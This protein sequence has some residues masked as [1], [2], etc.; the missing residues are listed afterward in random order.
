M[1]VSTVGADFIFIFL[2][3]LAVLAVRFIVLL[4]LAPW[5]LGG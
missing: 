1:G 4:F 5:R 2:A 3:V